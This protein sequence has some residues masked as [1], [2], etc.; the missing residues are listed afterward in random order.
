V[1]EVDQKY[2]N[3]STPFLR[4]E[5]KHNIYENI[6]P[7]IFHRRYFEGADYIFS[8]SGTLDNLDGFLPSTVLLY[9]GYD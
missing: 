6:Q 7:T 4:L 5:L 9:S 1:N 3:Q 2:H 8:L